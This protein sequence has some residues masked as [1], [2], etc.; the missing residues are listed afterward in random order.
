MCKT[1]KYVQNIYI[2]L[3]CLLYRS[4]KDEHDIFI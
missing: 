3:Y 4:D 2:S 1:M